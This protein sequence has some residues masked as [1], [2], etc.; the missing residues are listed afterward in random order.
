MTEDYQITQ[1]DPKDFHKCSNIWDINRRPDLAK[2]FY[3]ELLSRNRKIFIYSVNDVFI[4]E[5]ALVFD[6]GDPDYTI[7][8]QRIYLSHLCVRYENQNCGI[9]SIIVDYLIDYAKQHG[10]SEISVGV[11]IDNLRARHLYEKK[12]FINI[13]FEGEDAGGKFVK[14]MRKF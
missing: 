2:H 12:G 5:G 1:L 13:L 4:G 3:D 7:P 8:S 10:Y 9:G 11:N 6:N 14:L